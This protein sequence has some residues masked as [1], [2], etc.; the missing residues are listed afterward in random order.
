[1]E[2]KE[3]R[4]KILNFLYNRDEE[5]PQ[6]YVSKKDLLDFLQIDLNRLNSNVIYLRDKGYIT[7]M[8]SIGSIFEHAIIT[9][10][11]KDLVEAPDEFNKLFSIN[12]ITNSIGV[13]IGD[14]I[15][16]NVNI[17]NTF[18]EIYKKIEASNIENKS[19]IKK[20]VKQ[21]NDELKKTEPNMSIIQ[22][23]IGLFTKYAWIVEPI[24]K[25]VISYLSGGSNG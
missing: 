17:N 20:A 19:E 14:N 7:L 18:E 21:V 13:A 6:H 1:M 16:Q 4:A 15:N 9:A 25:L 5:K 11:G 10:Y 12:V 23:A 3:I 8:Q 24:M 2:N 22:K